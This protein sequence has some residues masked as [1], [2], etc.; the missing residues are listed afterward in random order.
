MVEEI[1]LKAKPF[2][3]DDG[4]HST[5]FT[6]NKHYWFKLDDVYKILE[7][8]VNDFQSKQLSQKESQRI[9]DLTESIEGGFWLQ[10]LI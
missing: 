4:S 10:H 9:L 2:M 1:R 7:P 6:K 5:K 8:K 3:K